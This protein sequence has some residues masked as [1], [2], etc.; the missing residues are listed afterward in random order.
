MGTINSWGDIANW[1]ADLVKKNIKK[2]KITQSVFQE[3][4]P[5]GFQNLTEEERAKKIYGYISDNITYSFIDFRQSGHVPQKPSKTI[6]TKLGDCKDV[7]TLFVT[8]AEMAGLEANLVLVLTNDNGLKSMALPNNEFNHC[9]AKVKLDGK[10]YF[11]ELTD[12]YLPFKAMPLSLINAKALVI[13]FQKAQNDKAQLIDIPSENALKNKVVTKTVVEVFDDKKLF[14]NNHTVYGANKSYYNEVFSSATSEE[15]RKKEMIDMY[16]GKLKKSINFESATSQNADKLSEALTFES[17]FSI[18]ERL[19]KLGSLKVTN[20]PFIDVV[21]TKALVESEKRSY[22]INYYS[23]EDSQTYENELILKLAN[24]SKFVE[25][26]DSKLLQYKG[27]QYDLKFEL[28][29][30]QELKITRN[31]YLSFENISPEEYIS[32]KEYIE[33]VLALE[34]QIIGFK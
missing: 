32:F 10:D 23:Y 25:I 17:A 2:D 30:D 11:L 6:T 21:Y 22:P 13:H 9:I 15:I 3:L 18:N 27:H 7:S 1:Y 16:N 26:P 28:M 31:V 12:K 14:K 24:G 29:N 20:I 19:Q 33:E 34:D 5:N 4:F 8:L